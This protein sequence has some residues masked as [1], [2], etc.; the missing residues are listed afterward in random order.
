[1]HGQGQGAGNDGTQWM[2]ISVPMMEIVDKVAP[3]DTIKLPK[4]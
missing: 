4:G 3:R 2:F 1:M